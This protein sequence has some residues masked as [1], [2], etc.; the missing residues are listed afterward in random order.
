MNDL[1]LFSV[2]TR[3]NN[4]VST[5]VDHLEMLIDDAV[6]AGRFESRAHFL[7]KAKLSTGYL[8]SLRKRIETDPDASM[9]APVAKRV[10]AAL[11]MSTDAL[12]GSL[13][14]GSVQ[15]DEY[16][17]RAWAI[18]AARILQFPEVAIQAVLNE[19]PGRDPGR[20]YWFRRIE[21]EAERLRPASDLRR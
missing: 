18:S 17:D 6:R 15:D 14:V 16:P 11:G 20:M 5:I 8:G 21:A 1:L 19:D 10:A 13:E 12:M 3:Q 7:R 4:C 2:S 9:T